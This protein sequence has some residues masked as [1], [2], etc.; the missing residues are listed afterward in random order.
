MA[1]KKSTAGYIRELKEMIKKRTGKEC[2]A[3]LLPQIRITAMNEVILDRLQEQLEVSDMTK[4]VAGS[5][6]QEKTIVEPLLPQYR[7]MQRTLTLQFTALG[8]NY[9]ITPNKV[10]EDARTTDDEE[11]PMTLFY[12]EAKKA[13]Q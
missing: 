8:L 1:R 9:N 3:W 4:T 11:N 7:D 13:R 5:M 12:K 10:K 2:E 6:G